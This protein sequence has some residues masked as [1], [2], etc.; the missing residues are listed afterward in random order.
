MAK[1]TYKTNYLVAVGWLN[2]NRVICNALPELDPSVWD[3][4]RIPAPIDVEEGDAPHECPECES[5]MVSRVIDHYGEETD[6]WVCESCGLEWDPDTY[7]K[8]SEYPEIFQW[9]LTDCS[10][11]DVE[12]L[13]ET[14]GLIF[15]YSSLLDLHVL[16]VDHYGTAWDHV[17]WTT[18]NP[19][20]ERKL[21]EKK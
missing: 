4:M 9:Y 13:S 7:E 3:N 16:C 15:S 19:I 14:F 17:G 10:D 11:S 5:R 12:Y 20:A 1:Q 18:T 2:N 6:E 21:G 8:E